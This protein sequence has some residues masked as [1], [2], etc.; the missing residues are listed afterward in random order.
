MKIAV[1]L[2][3]RPE[4]IKL[5][6]II[7]FLQNQDE[8]QWFVV[9]TN[10]HYSENMDKIFFEELWLLPAKYNLGINGWGHGE[11]T[12]RMLTEIEKVFKEEKPD[13]AIVQGDTNTVMAGA[14]VASKMN[15]EVAHVEAGLR[16]Y[17]R[18]MPEE[19]NR[20]V[21]DHISDYCF[22]PTEKQ[23]DILLSEWIESE[24]IYVVGNTVV[25]AVYECLRIAEP[26]KHEILMKYGIASG[27]YILVTSHRP[28]NVDSEIS[29]KSLLE[30]IS[31]I[32]QLSQMKVVFPIHPRTR[33]NVSKFNLDHL[34]SDILV[35]EPVWFIENLIFENEA[36][37]IATDSGGI[38]EEACILKKKTLIL[39]E[40]T[41]RPET[42]EVG[43]A[44]LVGCDK[45]KIINGYH[46]L[47][48]RS[49]DWYNPFWDGKTGET[50]VN[51]I[52]L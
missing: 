41:E 27:K 37:M 15:I 12:G 16:S 50:I 21:T 35:I 49:P 48:K 51:T 36:F 38:Q 33:S 13:V 28:A 22:P 10:Q 14:L 52:A 30:W 17:D 29:L 46:E 1:I 47:I 11:M 43:G 42:L 26:R 32:A 25:D 23:R 6:S 2:G 20:I 18:T 7:R 44:V 5:S 45:E 19:I 9:H 8:I 34:L 31:E 4:I 40:N 39:R 3:T 24:K